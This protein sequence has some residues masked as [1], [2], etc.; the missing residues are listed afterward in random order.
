MSSRGQCFRDIFQNI[1][2]QG[3]LETGLGYKPINNSGTDWTVSAG[4]GVNYIRYRSV[5][6]NLTRMTLTRFFADFVVGGKMVGPVGLEP[7][8]NRL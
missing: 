6:E 1:G 7:T 8:A 2:H 3:A 5:E 4:L